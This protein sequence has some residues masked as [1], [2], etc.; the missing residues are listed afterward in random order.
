MRLVPALALGG[1]EEGPPA[2][3]IELSAEQRRVAE[4]GEGPMV[5]VGPAGS[6]RT[7]ALAAR[8]ISLARRGVPPDRVLCLS[9]TRAGAS[10]LRERVDEMLEGPHEELA[11]TTFEGA[12]AD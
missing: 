3:P 4:H 12:A 11:I 1:V 7:D 2:P 9:R 10:R 6:G 8:L 5:V